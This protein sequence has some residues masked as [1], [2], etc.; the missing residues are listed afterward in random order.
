MV[1]EVASQQK[2]ELRH[3][4]R[5]RAMHQLAREQMI[6]GKRR[7][8]E[9]ANQ[10]R[11][12]QG[13]RVTCIVHVTARVKVAGVIEAGSAIVLTLRIGRWSGCPVITDILVARHPGSR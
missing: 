8:A 11:T 9:V 7:V 5:I 3:P 1:Y 6:Q 10:N 4:E 12:R 13:A 2:H